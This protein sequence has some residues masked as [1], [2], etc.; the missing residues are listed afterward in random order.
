M[1]M[2]GQFFISRPLYPRRKIPRHPLDR[3]LGGL[4]NAFKCCGEN[5]NLSPCRELNIDSTVI[6]SA[7]LFYIN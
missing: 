7:A 4:Q 5:K 1:E 6:K 2:S 3:R